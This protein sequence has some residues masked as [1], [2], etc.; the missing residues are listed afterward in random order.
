[1]R[2]LLTDALDRS[3]L[4]AIIPGG[5]GW[6]SNRAGTA[7]RYRNPA[8]AHGITKVRIRMLSARGL[9]RFRV[10]GRHATYGVASAEM[11][12]K[13]TLVI[14]SPIAQ[15]GQCGELLFPG[16]APSPHCAFT[17]SRGTLRCRQRGGLAWTRAWG[18]IPACDRPA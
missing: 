15:T 16:P 12:L 9:L 14:D 1:V 11:P 6:T 8:A 7:W 18:A 2:V 4:D 3:A 17:A 10:S 5:A 13:G